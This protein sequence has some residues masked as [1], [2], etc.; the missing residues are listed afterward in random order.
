M[1][2]E[3]RESF[4][5]LPQWNQWASSLPILR[6]QDYI[7]EIAG[8]ISASGFIDPYF[9]VIPPDQVTISSKNYRESIQARGLTS[10]Y[11]ALFTLFLDHIL[12]HGLCSPIYLG[13]DLT[14]FSDLVAQNFPYLIKSAFLAN[15]VM[16]M[17]LSQVRHEDPL[18]LKLPDRSF[19]VYLAPDIM[20]YTPSMEKFLREAHRILR[21]TGVLLATFSFRHG[22]RD[23]AILSEMTAD[24]AI[25]HR[26][27]PLFE[28]NPLSGTR[29]RLVYF[30]PGWDIL[31]VARDVGFQSAEIVVQSSRAHA[32]LGEEIAAVFTLKAVA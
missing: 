10:R 12:E 8:S 14:H 25:A 29:T 11:R 18:D 4:S 20:I 17:R 15:P 19:D 16:R 5:S 7:D 1:F 23:A 2:L 31:D 24:G 27:T 13:E 21:R 22:E 26:G 9:G 28:V 32:I 3:I 6:K 30:V